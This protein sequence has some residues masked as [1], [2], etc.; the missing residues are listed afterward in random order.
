M[1]DDNGLGACV[2]F[3]T[4]VIKGNA[5]HACVSA[6]ATE[7][8]LTVIANGMEIATM[9]CTPVRLREFV[10][11]F[12]LT[13]G[14]IRSAADCLSFECDEKKWTARIE[15]ANTPDPNMLFKR[16]YTSGCG[17]GVIYSSVVEIM[18]RYP[19]ED[20]FRVTAERINAG[21]RWLQGASPLHKRTGGTHTA[22]LDCGDDTPRWVCGDI[23]RHNAVDKVIGMA[24]LSGGDFKTSVLLNTGR[25]SSEI[26][27]KAR[28]SG[29]PVIVSLGAPTHQAVLLSR[30][31]NLTLVGFARGLSFTVFS[32]PERIV[33]DNV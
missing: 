8:P 3:E 17:K 30:E 4:V 1:N 2:E 20:G 22:A 13:S 15:L 9:A 21:V 32:S 11:G 33:H 18:A 23:G 6:V 26:V 31:M 12:L 28:R 24:L 5:R 16:L 19:A 29:I 14:L 10:A 7:V 27:H 25:V